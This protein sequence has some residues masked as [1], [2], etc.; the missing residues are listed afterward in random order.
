MASNL[1]AEHSR[2]CAF[3]D[4]CDPGQGAPLRQRLAD[5]AAGLA[6]LDVGAAP[7]AE[8]RDAPQEQSHRA[9][10]LHA[11]L[12]V[13]ALC[14]APS[15]AEVAACRAE[16]KRVRES[17]AGHPECGCQ[18]SET[19]RA[20]GRRMESLA[21]DRL[22]EL[23]GGPESSS[24]LETVDSLGSRSSFG[25]G[26]ESSNS[27]SDLAGAGRPDRKSKLGEVGIDDFDTL[28][29]ISRGT[30]GR[31]ML[32]RKRTTGD[33]FALKVLRKRDLLR[34]NLLQSALA[35]RDAL[36]RSGANP[37][38]IRFFYSFTSKQNLYLVMEYAPGGDLYSLLQAL[39]SLDEDMARTYVAETVL[40]LQYCH[41]RGI[42]HRDLKPD[43]LLISAS[44]HLKLA[45][46]GLSLV[47]LADQANNELADGAEPGTPQG[48]S[49]HASSPL[50]H[51]SSASLARAP[52]SS[53]G[54]G[55]ASL[56]PLPGSPSPLAAAG[57]G[58]PKRTS[59]SMPSAPACGPLLDNRACVGTPDYLAPEILLGTGH[60]PE[61]DWWA[62]GIIV[63]E[64][65][66][67]TPPFT[68]SDPQ[69]IFE[70]VLNRKLAF[71]AP[72]NELSPTAVALV[73]A[74]LTSDPERR[75]GHHG[76]E[77]VLAHPWF[78]EVDWDALARQKTEAAF[79]PVT[80][81][82]TDTSY[83]SPR[84]APGRPGARTSFNSGPGG[85]GPG[86]EGRR[87][88]RTSVGGTA[89]DEDED[90]ERKQLQ[91][92]VANSGG[93]PNAVL[94]QLN[95]FFA[96]FTFKNLS[97]LATFNLDLVIRTHR[98]GSATPRHPGTPMPSPH[99]SQSS[100][101]G[102]RRESAMSDDRTPQ[103]SPG[104]RAPHPKPSPQPPHPPSPQQPPQPQPL[105]KQP[106]PPIQTEGMP[107]L[108]TQA[109][110]RCPPDEL[111]GSRDD[112]DLLP[113]ESEMPAGW[114][115]AT[116]A[117]DSEP[118]AGEALGGD[119]PPRRVARVS[120]PLSVSGMSAA[121]ASQRSG[122]AFVP[123][124]PPLRLP[125]P[126]RGHSTAP[127]AAVGA[128]TVLASGSGA[129]GSGSGGMARGSAGSAGK[130][131]G[132]SWEAC[133]ASARGSHGSASGRAMCAHATAAIAAVA[134]AN[135]EACT[136]FSFPA[137]PPQTSG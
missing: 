40:A 114:L 53:P 41:G 113:A 82:D 19:L 26:F 2:A 28:K 127:T 117:D 18:P 6:A 77:E 17:L 78:K 5:L 96:S 64:L 134:A 50:G 90:D 35:E 131:S 20:F 66:D 105:P 69:S 62:L 108:R 39:G 137:T 120:S 76:S 30:F 36:A 33:L 88:A 98:E 80:L 115:D 32:A 68:A 46:F 38:V 57:S 83:F 7:K 42:V 49:S 94:E 67:G 14:P 106:P 122:D 73:E 107:S 79:V 59:Y 81:S 63:Y 136:S 27:M 15:P 54:A 133:G 102:M 51:C 65:L 25:A 111:A 21:L 109:P 101:A 34:K 97:Q 71:P 89:H 22:A 128:E 56:S 124:P 135:R 100:F 48:G 87:C 72:P 119:T 121:I 104:A 70:N 29:P 52:F 58:L 16:L 47:G 129:W 99:G 93:E 132:S 110:E 126:A 10:L 118:H 60:G 61:A 91:L 23:A 4:R 9:A 55:G 3:A 86:G 37:F 13:C 103:P 45:D 112:F 125:S 1:I 31:V 95:A 116:A 130:G 24:S 84:N 8:A 75:L 123:H 12:R 74:L 85:D 43:N 11:A 92:A 44:G